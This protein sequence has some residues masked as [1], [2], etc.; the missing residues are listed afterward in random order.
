MTDTNDIKSEKKLQFTQLEGLQKTYAHYLLFKDNSPTLQAIVNVFFPDD[1]SKQKLF[2][3]MFTVL[4][5][6]HVKSGLNEFGLLKNKSLAGFDKNKYGAMTIYIQTPFMG[7]DQEIYENKFLIDAIHEA[8]IHYFPVDGAVSETTNKEDKEIVKNAR[9]N[10]QKSLQGY[11]GT[12]KQPIITPAKDKLTTID[13]MKTELLNIRKEVINRL[14]NVL[15]LEAIAELHRHAFL[16]VSQ[17]DVLEVIAHAYN[18]S[19]TSESKIE[20]VDTI[21][22]DGKKYIEVDVVSDGR[23]LSAA[24]FFIKDYYDALSENK[25]IDIENLKKNVIDGL[26][27]RIKTE[28]SDK[29]LEEKETFA[30]LLFIEKYNTFMDP[31]TTDDIKEDIMSMYPNIDME[32]VHTTITNGQQIDEETLSVLE[33]ALKKEVEEYYTKNRWM[34]FAIVGD[35]LAKYLKKHIQSTP[36][37]DGFINYGETMK[38]TVYVNYTNNHY[39]ALV[40]Q[41]PTKGG[42][43]KTDEELYVYSDGNR[44]MVSKIKLAKEFKKYTKKNNECWTREETKGGAKRKSKS[45][46]KS[47]RK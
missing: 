32:D 33:D 41:P 44:Y 22:I 11:I 14:P 37:S 19:Q 36:N 42:A 46:K 34:T 7:M 2:I 9:D 29:L 27:E 23:C 1:A 17:K 40:E 18:P 3:Q 25:P 28:I 21:D 5:K 26:N 15:R 35:I 39:T 4:N 45:T 12:T 8:V 20:K 24:V 10:L 16:T 13:D 38:D 31:S 30:P 6:K 43:V 47:R